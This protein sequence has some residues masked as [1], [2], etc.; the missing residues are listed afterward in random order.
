MSYSTLDGIKTT[1]SRVCVCCMHM[2]IGDTI[3]YVNGH[4]VNIEN[5]DT[6]LAGLSNEVC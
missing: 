5:I 1:H 4:L 6:V 2:S 3:H